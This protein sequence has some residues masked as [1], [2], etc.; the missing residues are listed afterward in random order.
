[1]T[2]FRVWAPVAQRVEVEV[3]GE[4]L[5][6]TA[7]EGGWWAADVPAA[8]PGS[9][10]AFVLDGGEPLPDPRSPWQPSGVHGPSRVVDHQAFPWQD[11]RWQAGPLAA[12][13]LYELHVGTFTPSRDLRGRHRAARS[14]GGPRDY[15]H[16]ADARQRV[17][18][19]PG[20]G[21]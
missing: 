2:T 4:R 19:E 11:Q 10:Y 3:D 14:P 7:G 5:P 16:R 18:G 8:G 12:A 17:R 9:E 1:M 6:L 21:L 15:A 20:V 13:V